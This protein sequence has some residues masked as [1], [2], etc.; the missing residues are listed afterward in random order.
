MYDK[1]IITIPESKQSKDT[2]AKKQKSEAEPTPTQYL[3]IA[4]PV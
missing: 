3:V 4:C 2:M 1:P